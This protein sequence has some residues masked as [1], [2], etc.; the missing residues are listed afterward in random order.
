MI[1][2]YLMDCQYE[3]ESGLGK[4]GDWILAPVEVKSQDTTFSLDFKPNQKDVKAIMPR[5]ERGDMQEQ[6][7][8]L[9][10]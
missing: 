7:G 9:L 4:F 6:L 5:K 1:G 8:R 10:M 3:P 2:P